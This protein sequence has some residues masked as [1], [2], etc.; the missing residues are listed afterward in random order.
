MNGS[1]IAPRVIKSPD[2]SFHFC[3]RLPQHT[4]NDTTSIVTLIANPPHTPT[5]S[6]TARAFLLQ[7]VA[8]LT[9]L[10]PQSNLPV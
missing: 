1:S 5:S 4:Y 7:L 9:L 6:T 3:L 10:V 2:L 8:I